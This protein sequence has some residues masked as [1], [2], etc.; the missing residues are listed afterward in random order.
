MATTII[1]TGDLSLGVCD[2]FW[3]LISDRS[4]LNETFH[5]PIQTF[6][7]EYL[8]RQHNGWI[9]TL[10]SV[11]LTNIFHFWDETLRRKCSLSLTTLSVLRRGLIKESENAC[12]GVPRT[13]R[14]VIGLLNIMG[15]G[16]QEPEVFGLF[17]WAVFIFEL[18]LSWVKLKFV[19]RQQ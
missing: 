5:K 19:V 2:H 9:Y 8:N 10:L 12:V 13:G 15:G 4:Q 1:T 17:H 14:P 11:F 7:M 18:L 16:Y 6:G 3:S